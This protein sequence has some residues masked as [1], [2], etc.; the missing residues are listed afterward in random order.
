MIIFP[1][2]TPLMAYIGVFAVMTSIAFDDWAI[3]KIRNA[4][5]LLVY[6]FLVPI[7]L[8]NYASVEYMISSGIVSMAIFFMGYYK[9]IPEG[10]TKLFIAVAWLWPTFMWQITFWSGMM[11][12]GLI[13]RKKHPLAPDALMAG[14]ATVLIGSMLGAALAALI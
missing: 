13:A 14:L 3:H 2:L 9:K 4:K 6:V 7:L 11:V 10:D 12:Q 1:P 8:A 5:M